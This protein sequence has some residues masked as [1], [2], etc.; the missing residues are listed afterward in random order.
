[1][2]HLKT[3]LT[4]QQ[5]QYKIT[6]K[7]LEDTLLRMLSEAGKAAVVIVVVVVVV[8]SVFSPLGSALRHAW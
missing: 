3:E 2:E 6:L 7:E 1:M 5:N 8:L 4:Q